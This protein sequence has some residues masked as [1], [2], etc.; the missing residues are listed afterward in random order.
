MPGWLLLGV[1]PRVGLA[2]AAVVSLLAPVGFAQEPRILMIKVIDATGAFVPGATVTI[3]DETRSAV[4]D[5]SETRGV[6]LFGPLEVGR[7]SVTAVVAGRPPGAAV[8]E[9]IADGLTEVSVELGPRASPADVAIDSSDVSPADASLRL[10]VVD[11]S[12]ALIPEAT[13]T[14]QGSTATH[15]GE[16]SESPGVFLM[17]LPPGPYT[18]TAEATGFAMGTAAV[19]LESL[20]LTEAAV[21]LPLRLEVE[22]DVVEDL[23]I[24]TRDSLTGL[25]L[26]SE[27]LLSFPNNETEML[28]RLLELAGSRG[29]PGDVEIYV[30]GF[31]DFRRLPPK[32]AIELI[33]INAEPYSAEFSEPG[34]RRVEII[35]KPGSEGSFGEFKYD[36]NDE[37]LN[38]V[39]PF[40]TG[41]PAI[42]RRAFSG[43]YMA[44]IIPGRWGFYAYAGRWEQDENAVIRATVLD[45]DLQPVPFT[46]TLSAP[47]RINNFTVS[48]GYALANQT[49]LKA[50]WSRDSV[51]GGNQ[52]LRDGGFSLPEQ[53]YEI[54]N[55]AN[56]GRF[57]LL[58]VLGGT[59]VTEVRVQVGDERNISRAVNGQSA[60]IVLDSFIGGGNQATLLNDESTTSLQIDSKLTRGVGNH[61]LR[62]G[63]Q[64]D[65]SSRTLVDVAD[66]GGTFIFGPDVERDAN[67]TPIVTLVDG[68]FRQREI[69]ALENY[70]RTLAGI[71]GAAPTFF[72]ITRGAAG[73]ALAQ[74]E[75]S[76]FAQADWQPTDDL[77]LSYGLRYEAQTNLSDKLNLAPRLGVAWAPGYGGVVRAGTGLFYERF[78]LGLT[79]DTIRIARQQR[80]VVSRPDFFAVIPGDLEART[81]DQSLLRKAEDLAAPQRLMSNVS[82]ERELPWSPFQSS[83]FGAVGYTWDRGS[84]LPRLRDIN[85]PLEPATP[86]PF[87]RFGQFLLYDSVG[88]SSRHELQLSLRASF[89]EGSRIFTNYTLSST[90]SDA[91]TPQEIPANSHDLASEFGAASTHER[92]RLFVSGTMRLPGVWL[93]VP[94]LTATSGRPFNIITGFDNNLDTHL[95]DRPSFADPA[96]DFDAILTPWGLLDPTPEAGD[97][98]IPRNFGRGTAQYRLDLTVAK[99]FMLGGVDASRS[100]MTS[101]NFE[102][103]LNATI[104]RDF[105]GVL[106]SPVFGRANTAQPG[107]R[108]SLGLSVN[109]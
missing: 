10:S 14:V 84:R 24:N 18:V 4:V 25:I 94:S 82:Y 38:A 63:V 32:G 103:L 53:A 50:E 36:F 49:R 97:T 96:L 29:R 47:Y 77:T 69:T 33:Q 106:V 92:H 75:W 44:P 56:I 43:Y 88:R 15:L 72:T 70:R 45:P 91:D 16:E 78:D 6:F 54:D 58:S 65:R 87:Q 98:I 99:V 41:K 100:L 85:A 1:S 95:T 12:G 9:L 90:A 17:R 74:W 34:T 60:V 73:A 61:T 101:V 11:Q 21:E 30:D 66:F 93:V 7:Y 79:L 28:Y 5:E 42:Q 68:S 39:E 59:T 26:S 31:R 62:T 8:V 108:I 104:L 57:S 71:P 27:D 46:D 13:V 52:G 23:R 81:E 22:I 80:F 107:R 2:L 51:T 105:N 3:E 102:N 86:R 19:T 20:E 76:A 83:L 40:A 89:N 48:S 55:V 109:F 37:G 35:T 64:L 67:G